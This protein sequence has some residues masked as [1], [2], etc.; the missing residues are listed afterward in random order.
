MS[1]SLP[2]TTTD[3]RQ[4]EPNVHAA[5]SGVSRADAE[6]SGDTSRRRLGAGRE[7]PALM[8]S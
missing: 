4:R 6:P 7:C 5:V 2:R 3:I 1:G 8:E